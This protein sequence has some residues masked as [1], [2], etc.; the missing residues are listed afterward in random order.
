[1]LGGEVE[2]MGFS[3]F[4][5]APIAV[6]GYGCSKFQPLSPN[7]TPDIALIL[8]A[9]ADFAAGPFIPI[10]ITSSHPLPPSVCFTGA[11]GKLLVA[12]QGACMS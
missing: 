1:M 12:L 9:F 3:R 6:S 10:L 11:S 2:L 7:R 5:G 4:S 8:D